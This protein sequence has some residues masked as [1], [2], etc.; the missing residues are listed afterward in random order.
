MSGFSRRAFLEKSA[1]G[2]AA[3]SLASAARELQ[4]KPLGLPI[5]SQTWPPST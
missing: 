1:V 2:A 5:G 4:A 3:A